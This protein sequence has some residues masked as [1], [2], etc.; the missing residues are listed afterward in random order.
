MTCVTAQGK[1]VAVSGSGNVAQYTVE[2][3][4]AL[5]AVPISLSDSSGTIIEEDGFDTE[6]LAIVMDIKNKQRARISAYTEMSTTAK[7]LPGICFS[8]LLFHNQLICGE[9]ETNTM[10]LRLNFQL[11][12]LTFY[13]MNSV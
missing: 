4:L 11:R 6:K 10:S 3:L 8:Q 9:R 12:L 7:F 5:G 2:K 1:R 13:G